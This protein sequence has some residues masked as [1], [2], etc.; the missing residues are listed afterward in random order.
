MDVLDTKPCGNWFLVAEVTVTSEGPSTGY[1]YIYT[2]LKLFG[3][4][5]GSPEGAPTKIDQGTKDL[6]LNLSSVEG[7]TLESS[8]EDLTSEIS[9]F[10]DAM[11]YPM[12][13]DAVITGSDL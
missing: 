8:V 5:A 9:K 6:G 2:P 1:Q 7:L 3:F 12:G 4:L 10:E 11:E 13:E